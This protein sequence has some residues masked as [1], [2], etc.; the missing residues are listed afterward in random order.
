ASRESRRGD[1]RDRALREA[2]RARVRGGPAHGR[3]DQ[4]N[5][6][7]RSEDLRGR[8]RATGRDRSGQDAQRMRAARQPRRRN[9]GVAREAVTEWFSERRSLLA[10]DFTA[11]TSLIIRKRAPAFF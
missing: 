5:R 4:G 10:G 9:R 3:L 6:R 7:Q 2:E 8:R 11:R 1:R